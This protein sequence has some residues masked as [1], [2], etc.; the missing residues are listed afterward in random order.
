MAP[1][2]MRIPRATYRLQLTEDF[3]FSDAA[4]LV[5]YLAELGVSDLYASPYLKARPGSTHGYDVVDPTSLN[6]E[7]G[8]EKEYGRL[9]E[10]LEEH[11]MGQ[12]L[13]IVPNHMGVG[14]DNAWWS[15]VLENGPASEYAP[16][17]DIDWC[18]V[19]RKELCGKVLLPVLGDHYRVA[20]ERGELR[21][22]F[23]E[24]SFSIN[25][26]EHRCPIDPQTYPMILEGVALPEEDEFGSEMERLVIAFGDL[27]SRDD[28]AE[29]SEAERARN[30][31]NLKADLASLCAKSSGVM[32]AVEERIRQL[33]QGLGE[34]SFDGLHLLLQAQAYRLA[35]WRVGSDEINYRRFFAVNELAGVRVEDEQVF[36]ATHGLILQLVEKGAVNGLRIDH[37]DGLRDPAGYLGRLHDAVVEASGGPIYTLVEKILAHHERLP[38]D[39]PVAGTTGYEFT[40]LLNGL[41]VDRDGESGMDEAYESFIGSSADFQGLLY[42]CKHKVM[43]TALSSEL[44]ALSRRLRQ[45]SEHRRSHDFSVESLRAA[46]SEVVAHFPVYRTYIGP[47]RVSEVDRRHLDLAVQEAKKRST[48]D[49]RVFDFI[50]DVVLRQGPGEIEAAAFTS[51]FQQYTGPVMA[52]GM[53]DCALYIYN[54]LVS[55]NEVGGEPERFGVSVP[56]F[57]RLNAERVVRWPHSML[58]TST[59]DTKRSEDVRARI[60]V[61]SEIPDEWNE[62]V[63]S[64]SDLNS[65]FRRKVDGDMAPGRNDEYLLYQTL[66]GAWPPGG[67]DGEKME[68]FRK[69]MKEYMEKAMREAQ[70]RTSWTDANEEYEEAVAGFVD[71]LL[72]ESNLFFQE[73]LPFQRR[74][75]R[76][77]ALNSLSQSLIK[78]TVPGVPDVYQ[79]N[80]IWDFSLVDPDNRRPVDF[81]LRKS[82]L[83]ELRELDPSEIRT[84]LEDGV[85][86][87]GRPKLYI[88]WKALA[89]RRERSELFRDG[90]YMALQISGESN[91]HLVAFA[92]RHGNEVAIT[93]APRLCAKMMDA[94]G[95]LLPDPAAWG[96]TSI[97]LPDGLAAYSNV[98]TGEVVVA[99]E[100]N[101]AMSLHVGSLLRN[102]P[103]ALLETGD[104]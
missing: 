65:S 57:H 84:L 73:F 11:G 96:D 85:W 36:E 27:P 41:F 35:Y 68:A 50:S 88:I 48:G 70:V 62:R 9:V 91:E 13:D 95:S 22:A 6:P 29:G 25:Y 16:F 7:L 40:N 89:M 2:R 26:Y 32:D 101:G 94:D 72:T 82:L 8:S 92:R 23:E 79:G 21:L 37:P 12:L 102:F 15:D 104:R 19:D 17:F 69:R 83:A 56:E 38:E 24:S 20:L 60:D 51:R 59:H 74:V 63:V 64:W 103:V 58:S 100:R 44:N 98:L 30:A 33:N 34:P 71:A 3:T 28:T 54:R 14:S 55:L 53:E 5:P 10:A 46:L 18:P 4:D 45:I 52:K 67:P 49:P 93:V 75:A 86:Q 81:E 43:R 42:E 80:D 61:L 1:G 47:G 31:A 66:L 76:I 77:G 99:E 78:L 90:G 39:W 87:D 97:L